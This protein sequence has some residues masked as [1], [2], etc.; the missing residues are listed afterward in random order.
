MT[1]RLLAVMMGGIVML[2][3]E[4]GHAMTG[5]ESSVFCEG[6]LCLWGYRR[7]SPV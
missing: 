6:L 1:L 4:T 7:V 5:E 3:T 2:L